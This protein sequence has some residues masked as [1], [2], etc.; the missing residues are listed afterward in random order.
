MDRLNFVTN[1]A[2]KL[3]KTSKGMCTDLHKM[4]TRH[5]FQTQGKLLTRINRVI[6]SERITRARLRCTILK[7]VSR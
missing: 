1:L 7:M 4:V 6:I 3:L 2:I 5:S